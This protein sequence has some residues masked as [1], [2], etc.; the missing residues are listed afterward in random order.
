[1]SK[2]NAQAI[3]E[4]KDARAELELI[5]KRDRAETDAYIA[6]NSRVAETEKNVPFW[7]R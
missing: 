1:M 7:R 4:H 2:K 3:A 6:A 5:S